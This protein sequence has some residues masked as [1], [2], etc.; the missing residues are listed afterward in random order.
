MLDLKLVLGIILILHR[1][2]LV[3]IQRQVEGFS[4]FL[5]V[6]VPLTWNT[7]FRTIWV[8]SEL[9]G[10]FFSDIVLM[11]VRFC[12][13]LFH[14]VVVLWGTLLSSKDFFGVVNV[15]QVL[16]GDDGFDVTAHMKKI[17]EE[18]KENANK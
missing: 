9:L 5:R 15:Q 18:G 6:E 12:F 3:Q 7:C 8:F 14:D 17:R 1:D 2:N 16:G 13:K 11:L 4:F 10:C